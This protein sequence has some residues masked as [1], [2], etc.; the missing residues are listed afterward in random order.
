MARIYRNVVH[1]GPHFDME[2]QLFLLAKAG[3]E[4]WKKWIEQEPALKSEDDPM[5]SPMRELYQQLTKTDIFMGGF[6]TR[7]EDKS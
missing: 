5:L 4:V 3:A 7:I 6:H 1:D 2:R